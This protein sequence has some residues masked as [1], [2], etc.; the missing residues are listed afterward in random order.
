MNPFGFYGEVVG[1]GALARA[2]KAAF[3]KP[4]RKIKSID[5]KRSS[6][7]K[8]EIKKLETG[9]VSVRDRTPAGNKLR[10]LEEELKII[11]ADLLDLNKAINAAQKPLKNKVDVKK[12]KTEIK[13]AADSFKKR[14]PKRKG[15]QSQKKG[16][17]KVILIKPPKVTIPKQIDKLTIFCHSV[18]S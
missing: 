1:G 4:L 8:T 5:I 2:G 7:I 15:I 3:T 14:T 17:P 13:T 11:D 10:I 9:G 16:L 12:Q 6:K 18:C